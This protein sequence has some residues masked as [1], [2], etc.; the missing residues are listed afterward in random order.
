MINSKLPY[1][2]KEE[3]DSDEELYYSWYLSELCDHGYIK[4]VISQPTSFTLSSGLNHTFIKSMKTKDKILEETIIKPSVYTTDFYIKWTDKAL[5]VF[6]NPLSTDDKIM[7]G[8][9]TRLDICDDSLNSYTEVKPE[10]D[11]N[12]M[13]RLARTNIKWVW[14]NHGVYI[15]LSVIPKLFKKTFTPQ[16]YLTTNLSG[17]PRKLDYNPRSLQEYLKTL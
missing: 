6:I 9:V 14:D 16:R 11:Q 4:S 2:N 12:N 5:G 7:K 17:K 8:L 13:T 3:L 10:F 15:N 1:L